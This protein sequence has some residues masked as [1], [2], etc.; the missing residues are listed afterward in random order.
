MEPRIRKQFS[1]ASKNYAIVTRIWVHFSPSRQL[2]YNKDNKSSTA[3]KV[4]YISNKPLDLMPFGFSFPHV[5]R[6]SKANR[7]KYF[8][9]L[10]Q[11]LFPLTELKPYPDWVFAIIILLCIIPLLPIPVV[12]L[13]HLTCRLSRRH[14]NQSYPNAYCNDGF[15]I[16][17]QNTPTQSAWED[18]Q[19]AS[20]VTLKCLTIK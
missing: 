15:Q 2:C 3:M 4:A 12:A 16:E 17:T 6:F 13:Y 9:P 18:S 1:S 10:S 11:E 19:R 20:F 5:C 8:C 7:L 14:S